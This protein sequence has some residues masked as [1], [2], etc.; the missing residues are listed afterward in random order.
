MNAKMTPMRSSMNIWPTLSGWWTMQG[1]Y[2]YTSCEFYCGRYPF[3][4]CSM[5][6]GSP[7]PLFVTSSVS[8]AGGWNASRC[9]KHAFEFRV[10]WRWEELLDL[11]ISMELYRTFRYE[12][13]SLMHASQATRLFFHAF[14][15]QVGESSNLDEVVS[16]PCMCYHLLTGAHGH[17]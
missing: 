6:Y 12:D 3:P 9:V 10:F 8:L 17:I 15:W 14:C 4:L 5:A 16:T 7:F 1:P 11:E 2:I 13:L